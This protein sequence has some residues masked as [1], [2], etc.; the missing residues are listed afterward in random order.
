MKLY[1]LVTFGLLS[2]SFALGG[3]A[4]GANETKAA[5]SKGQQALKALIE[6]AKQEPKA[7]N[8]GMTNTLEPVA[9]ELISLFNKKFGL[10]KKI[11]WSVGGVSESNKIAQAKTMVAA[12]GSPEYIVYSTGDS[13]LIGLMKG[14]FATPVKNWRVLLA[15]INPLVKSGKL[16]P[17]VVSPPA[18]AGYGFLWATR[19]KGMLYNT[20]LIKRADLPKNIGELA[21]PKYKGRYGLEPYTTRWQAYFYQYR[22]RPQEYLDLLDVIGKNTAIVARSDTLRQRLAFGEFAFVLEN[23]YGWAEI[24][25]VNPQVPVAVAFFPGTDIM[26]LNFAF[27]PT[28]SAAPAT[29]T[30]WAMFMTTPEAGKLRGRVQENVATGLAKIDDQMRNALRGEKLFTWFGADGGLELLKWFSTKEGRVFAKKI[31]QRVRQKRKKRK[32]RKRRK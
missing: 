19:T 5:E 23:A 27:V 8:N 13:H 7:V 10:K 18:V 12:G 26:S 16:K 24:K 1:R 14:K 32:R 2:I 20:K 25:Q 6:K 4:P 3:L 28:R 30:L 9:P 17:D 21:H 31:T 29:A 15:E 11:R 22:D